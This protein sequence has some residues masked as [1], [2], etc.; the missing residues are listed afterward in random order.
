M[1]SGKS[2]HSGNRKDVN[3]GPS[4][5]RP[6]SEPWIWAETCHIQC[7]R[8]RAVTGGGV[9]ANRGHFQI[10][11]KTGGQLSP[12]SDRPLCLQCSLERFQKDVVDKV[13]VWKLES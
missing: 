13:N 10:E 11:E 9:G 7:L 12:V 2:K 4:S 5:R 1:S 6:T 3:R 8:T